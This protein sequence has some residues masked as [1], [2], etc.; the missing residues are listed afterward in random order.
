M[1]NEKNKTRYWF[2]DF[3]QATVGELFLGMDVVQQ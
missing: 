1:Q 3:L 2:C